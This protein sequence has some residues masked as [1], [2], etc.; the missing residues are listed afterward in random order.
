MGTDLGLDI[1]QR[2]TA[3]NVKRFFRNDFEK[4]ILRSGYHRTD[5]TS[6]Q[7]DP[8][9]IMGHGGNS[10]ENKM[11]II[12]DAQDKCKAVYHAIDQCFDSTQQPFRTILKSLYIDELKDWQ[13]AA[14]VQYS[15]SRYNELKKYALCQF[16]DTIET[17][18]ILYGVD[19]PQLKVPKNQNRSKIG[20]FQE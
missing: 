12:F 1:D 17:W 19:I 5:L 18:K 9:G 13:V 11:A 7:L 6:P 4:Y 2:A 10:A 8:T 16:A 20:G 15:D 14:K 3:E